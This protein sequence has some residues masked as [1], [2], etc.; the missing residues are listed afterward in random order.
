[1][2]F[3]SQQINFSLR[4]YSSQGLEPIACL[5]QLVLR[6]FFQG[7]DP[8]GYEAEIRLRLVGLLRLRTNGA[9]TSTPKHV[10]IP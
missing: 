2:I 4:S 8:L 1:M 5:K 3:D 6:G 9:Y 7:L 10:F